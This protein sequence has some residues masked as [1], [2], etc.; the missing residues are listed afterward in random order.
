M[1]LSITDQAVRRIIRSYTYEAG[2]RNLERELARICRKLA[3]RLAE[4]RRIPARITPDSLHKYLGPPQYTPIEAERQDEVGVVT[5]VAWTEGGG[6]TMPIEVALTP[7]KGGLQIT[8]QVGEVMQ[9]SA[10]AALSYLKSRA[11]QLLVEYDR[12]EKHDTHIHVPEGS[13]PKDGPSAGISLATALISAYTGRKVHKEVGMTGEITL[14]GKVLPVGGIKEKVL[15]AHRAGLKT[16]ILP[17]KNDKDLVDVPKDAKRDL[18]FVFVEHMDEVLAV[19]L[20][21]PE[22]IQAE[23]KKKSIAKPKPGAQTGKKGRGVRRR[24]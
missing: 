13:I 3:R 9:E 20:R 14:R 19:A 2:V 18:K 5:G 16:V 1:K 11:R 10:Q 6:D 17:K 21:P 12:F 15:A 7:G 4:G 22:P 24:V 8:G 23:K